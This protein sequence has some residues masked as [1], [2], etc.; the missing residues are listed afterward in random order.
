M[1]IFLVLV[2]AFMYPLLSAYYVPATMRHWGYNQE[3]NRRHVHYSVQSEI[4]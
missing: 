3:Q 2:D 1:F 4:L